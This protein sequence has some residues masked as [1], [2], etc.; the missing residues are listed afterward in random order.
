MR[1]AP[2][3]C[4]DATDDNGHIFIS[5]AATLGI[6]HHGVIRP[7]TRLPVRRIGIVAADLAIRGITIDH[8]IH[9]A[10]R[11]P[12][13]QV[14]LSESPKIADTGPVRL[15]NDA[16]PES[17]G[18]KHAADHRHAETGMVHVGIAAD[19]NNIAGIP[20]QRI[21]LPTGNRQF[22]GHAETTGPVL[23]VGEYGGSGKHAEDIRLIGSWIIPH[24][25]KGAGD[26]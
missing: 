4:L 13:K 24:F 21:H 6:Y 14:G 8:G 18:L 22:R 26:I 7:F 23:T 19:Q 5:L 16:D 20:A 15:G 3:A 2:Q 9:V 12:V 25:K 1:D 17:L 11:D 10:R